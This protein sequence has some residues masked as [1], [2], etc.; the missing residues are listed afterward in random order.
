MLS[1]FGHLYENGE[2]MVTIPFQYGTRHGVAYAYNKDGS[3]YKEVTYENGK[4]TN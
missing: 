2:T 4:I 1:Q 3:V